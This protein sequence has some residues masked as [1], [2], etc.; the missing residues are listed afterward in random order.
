MGMRLTIFGGTGRTG[1]PLVAQALT[2]GHEVTALARSPEKAAAILPLDADG[3]TLLEGDLLDA[4]AVRRASDGADAVINVAGPVKGAPD[5]LQQ[6]AIGHLLAAMDEHGVRRIVTLTGAG[7]RIPGDT[8][9]LVDRAFG[10]AL[11]VLQGRLLEDS[12][13]YVAA[14]RASGTDWTIVR[15]PRLLDAPATGTVVIRTHVG[16]GTSSK[17]TREDLATVLLDAVADDATIGTAPVVSN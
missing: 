13:A 12:V 1:Q 17:L 10:T 7:V 2:G 3:L 6:R 8:P 15:A 4:A 14:V 16:Q 5:D 11:K 9:K